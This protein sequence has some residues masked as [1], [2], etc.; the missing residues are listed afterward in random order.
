MENTFDENDIFVD[1][2]II[3]SEEH[4]LEI[5][6]SLLELEKNLE[7]YDQ[8]IIN[9]LFR[10]IHTIKGLSGMLDF[11]KLFEFSHSWE[12]LLDRIRKKKQDLNIE[13]INISFESLDLLC[14]I[15]ETIK[16]TKKDT[17][18]EIS[19]ITKK[20]NIMIGED[21]IEKPEN[22]T[23]TNLPNNIISPIFQKNISNSEKEKLEKEVNSEKNIYEIKMLLN[24]DC[25]NQGLSY[26]SMCI[27]LEMIGE[28]INI[29][30]NVNSIPD[31][32]NFDPSIFDLEINILFTTDE[33]LNRIHNALKNKDIRVEKIFPV[34]IKID[35]KTTTIKNIEKANNNQK[36]SSL[37]KKTKNINI[38]DTIRVDTS[39]LDKLLT[40]IGE[41]VISKTQL[42]R[43]SLLLNSITNNSEEIINK[44]T[45]FEIVD[46]LT[47]KINT[48]SRLNSELQ[49]TVM[50]IRMLPI[51]NVFN[52]FGRVIRDLTQELGKKVDLIIEGESTELDKTIIE[53]ISDPLVHI[54]RNAIDHGIES[55]ADRIS[56]GKNETGLLQLK[57][58]QQGNGIIISIKDDGKGLNAE[59]IKEKAI[60]KGLISYDNHLSK[61][62]IINLIFEPGFTT[63]SEVTG[64]SGRGVGM[65]VVR[66]NISKLKGTI[67]IETKEDEGTLFIIKL[68][69]TLA[70]IQSLIINI[71]KTNFAIPMSTVIESYRARPDEI[72][73][74]NGL[75][76]LK[77]R[78]NIL[79]VLYFED[80]F[81]LDKVDSYKNNKY[82]YI[83]VIGVADQKVAFV[84]TSLVGQHEVVIKPLNDPF[85]SVRGIS[86]SA[87]LG[88][89]V[90]LI[91]DPVSILINSKSIK[92]TEKAGILQ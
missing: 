15:I 60:E 6:S 87:I 20:L 31:I 16:K 43:I 86:G 81:K 32:Q 55:P 10:S 56:K 79:P 72:V 22:E 18:V 47:E 63:T 28:I 71:S 69:L 9:T 39:K 30:P 64:I 66:K 1:Q 59:I 82:I 34:A 24:K 91:L 50:R 17:T 51:G 11:Q 48:F 88:E 21:V 45:L 62:E 89:E 8:E 68:P 19:E 35:E 49:E 67:E 54:I 12:T 65:D 41:Q 27:N 92:K 5:E 13:T 46:N 75:P 33:D 23:K 2:F 14:N 73:I 44:K 58:E 37:D 4:I 74:I 52:R 25:F 80:Y 84:V 90:I 53:E 61:N 40:L 42:E 7:N 76:T 3:E 36:E 85:V 57:A 26:F 83:V 77:L 38:T 29:S 78:E 70:I